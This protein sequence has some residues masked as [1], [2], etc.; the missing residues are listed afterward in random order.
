MDCH[1]EPGPEEKARHTALRLI[2]EGNEESAKK[3]QA[4]VTVETGIR[5]Q[6]SPKDFPCLLVAHTKKKGE[7]AWEWREK[8]EK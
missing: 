4:T 2:M 6:V 3:E 8:I 5:V 7:T 1:G